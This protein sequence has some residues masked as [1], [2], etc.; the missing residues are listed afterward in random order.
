MRNQQVIRGVGAQF[1]H[2][3][4]P[5]EATNDDS[6]ALDKLQHKSKIGP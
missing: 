5:S 4:G 2:W 6:A 1:W 3:Y